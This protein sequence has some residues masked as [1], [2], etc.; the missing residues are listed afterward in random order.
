[1]A[2]PDSGAARAIPSGMDSLQP[3]TGPRFDLIVEMLKDLSRATTPGEVNRA[4]ILRS[5]RLRPVDYAVSLST[6][7]LEPG[8]YRITRRNDLG[9]ILSGKVT[10]VFAEYPA[11]SDSLPIHRDG[12][13][14]RMIADPRPKV[15]HRLEA[16]NDPVLG[17][18]VAQMRSALV[19]PLYDEG[20]AKN[21]SVQF[22]RSPEGFSPDEC[23]TTIMTANLV[24][25]TN[26]RMGLTREVRELNARLNKQ[27][28]DLARIQRALLPSKIPDIPGLKIATSYLT[29]DQAGG[30]YYDFFEFENGMWGILIADVSGHGAAAAAVMAMLH[31]ILHAYRS[32]IDGASIRPEEVLRFANRRLCA[33]SIESSFVTAFFA[34]YNPATATLS[35]SR[36]GHNP[37]RHKDGRTGDMRALDGAG[38]LP[39][40]VFEDSGLTSETIRLSSGDTVILYTDGITE[41]FDAERRM[42]GVDRLDAALTECSGDP[43]CVVDSVHTALY[44]HTGSRTRADDQTIV[45]FRYVG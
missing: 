31:A 30:D 33:A 14:A 36:S 10:P 20:E 37:P 35:Y 17:T 2:A 12:I 15:V 5:L 11:P 13:L 29:S 22:R 9:P 39:L 18:E 44:A 3:L 8:A 38:S 1:M 34:V 16:P 6:R 32:T 45:A 7:G 40:G 42:F 43:D 19:I 4:F 27:F 25:G 41:A 23:E 28:E 26:R 24:G 21:W